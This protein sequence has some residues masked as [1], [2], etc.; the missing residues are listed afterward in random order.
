MEAHYH[1]W[2]RSGKIFTMIERP[3]ESR[4]TA[5]KAAVKLRSD[6]SARLVLACSKCPESRPSRRRPPRW[7]VVARTVAA[8]VGAALAAER[9]RTVGEDLRPAK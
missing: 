2:T 4:K 6:T 5:H 9:G 7:P 3:F 8:A 1:V